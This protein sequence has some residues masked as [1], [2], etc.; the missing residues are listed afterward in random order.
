M[1]FRILAIAAAGADA[2]LFLERFKQHVQSSLLTAG[3]RLAS[4]QPA[5]EFVTGVIDTE[6]YFMTAVKECNFEDAERWMNLGAFVNQVDHM[7]KNALINAVE[8]HA[9]A[10]VMLFNKYGDTS[11]DRAGLS[12]VTQNQLMLVRMLIQAGVYVNQVDLMGKSALMYAIIGG[13]SE[14][15]RT[16]IQTDADVNHADHNG[17]TAVMYAIQTGQLEVVKMLLDS[18]RVDVNHI[19]HMGKS[20]LIYAAEGGRLELVKMLLMVGADVRQVDNVQMNA[21]SYAMNSERIDIVMLLAEQ[22]HATLEG[23]GQG[24]HFTSKDIDLY[25]SNWESANARCEYG[26]RFPEMPERTSLNYCLIEGILDKDG[27][28]IRTE[29]TSNSAVVLEV[30]LRWVEDLLEINCNFDTPTP[31]LK[32]RALSASQAMRSILIPGSDILAVSQLDWPY[33]ESDVH[34]YSDAATHLCEDVEVKR[35][36]IH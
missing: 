31:P 24:S 30:S 32:F 2:S 14:V 18:G 17:Q 19:D 7:G 26:G 20:A 15:V 5:V 21:L 25:W 16:L 23:T 33:L 10:L 22:G 11:V 13:R 12:T 3:R 9:W 8:C 34:F 35:P 6:R 4:I 1:Y 27:R 28:R 36:P 29:R